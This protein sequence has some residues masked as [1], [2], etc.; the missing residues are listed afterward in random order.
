VLIA[1]PPYW[2]SPITPSKSPQPMLWS[3]T[4]I[5]RRLSRGLIDGP[6]GTAHDLN[7][8][9]TSS[10]KSQCMLVAWCCW[11]TKRAIR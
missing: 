6:F 8:P 3:S 5:A 10:R 1:P 9:P 2:P 4:A 7:V 11:I